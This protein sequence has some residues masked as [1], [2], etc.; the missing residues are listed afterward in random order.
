MTQAARA[1]RL[2]HADYVAAH[3]ALV[4]LPQQSEQA[5]RWHGHCQQLF[6]RSS[7]FT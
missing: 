4:A 5:Q 2:K 6:P 7:Y 3:K 1:G